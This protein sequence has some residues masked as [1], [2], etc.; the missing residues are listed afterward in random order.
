VSHH[1]DIEVIAPLVKQAW[2][3]AFRDVA[4]SPKET[5]HGPVAE[6]APHDITV[7]EHLVEHDAVPEGRPGES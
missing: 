6:P 5:L 1:F 7:H 4:E 2:M 3:V